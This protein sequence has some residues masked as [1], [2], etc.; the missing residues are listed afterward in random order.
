LVAVVG[1]V[2]SGK[3][4]V[5]SAILGEMTK[6]SGTVS[7]RGNVAFVAQQAWIQNATLRDNILFGKPYDAEKYENTIRV[8][9]LTQ[10]F[11]FCMFSDSVGY[12]HAPQ[13]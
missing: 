11:F 4:S 12:C 3:S 10:V 1:A 5:L 13:W 7:V 9:E 8:C 6:T 2:G